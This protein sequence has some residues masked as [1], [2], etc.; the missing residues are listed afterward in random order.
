MSEKECSVSESIS[1]LELVAE[2]PPT[3]DP[4]DA[5]AAA[6]ADLDAVRELV[7]RAHR[8]VVPELVTG[9]SV[10]GILASVEP[11]RAAYA[12]L[13]EGWSAS[14]PRAV[15][16]PAGGGAPLPVDPALIPASE[17]IR[18]GLSA[19]TNHRSS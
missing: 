4:D 8:D 6:M 13:E 19:G 15:S 12:R 5:A 17:K 9:D 14:T 7:L 3:P 16:V 1:P 11:A 18:R 2:L 10:A